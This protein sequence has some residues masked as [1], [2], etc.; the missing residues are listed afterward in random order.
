MLTFLRARPDFASH[1]PGSASFYSAVVSVTRSV[2]YSISPF[3]HFPI[4][5]T[6]CPW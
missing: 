6:P 5:V 2:H 4:Q 3:P 1:H